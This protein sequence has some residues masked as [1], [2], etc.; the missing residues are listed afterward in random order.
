MFTDPKKRYKKK[1]R[2]KGSASEAKSLLEPVLNVWTN[3]MDSTSMMHLQVRAALTAAVHMDS[4][5]EDCPPLLG[6]GHFTLPA[7]EARA[8]REATSVFLDCFAALQLSDRRFNFTIKAH[9]LSHT[10][11]RCTDLNPRCSWCYMGEDYMHVVKGLVQSCCRGVSLAE[12]SNKVSLK[13]SI[14]MGLGMHE[15][16]SWITR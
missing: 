7:D 6:D 4:L 2:V 10:A 14:A 5:L 3:L 1:P 11:L 9:H 8:F 12:L 15:S 16:Q 13:T